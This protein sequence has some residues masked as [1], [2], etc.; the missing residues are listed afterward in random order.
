M[1]I[2][3]LTTAA[4]RAFHKA[5]FELKKHSPEILVVAGVVGTVASAVMA[6]KATTKVNFVL[7][8]TKSKIDI[9]HDG[10]E[11]GEVKGLLENGE[12]GMVPYS[13]EDSQKDLTIV[14]AQTGLKL[15][16]LYAPAVLLGAASITSILVGHRILHKRNLAL[17]AAYTAVDTGFKQYRG[18]VVERLGEKMDK[19]LLYNIKAKEIEETVV[20]EDGT[21]TTVK[22]TVEV[23]DPVGAMSPYTVCF[24]ETCTGWVRDAERN[25]FFLLRQQQHANELLQSRGHL[26]LNEVLDMVGAQRTE[27][28]QIVGWVYKDDNKTGDNYIDFGIFNIHSEA[29]R[30]FV[31]GLEKSIWLTFNVDGPI[32]KCFNK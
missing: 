1:K 25:K 16:K 6:C 26:F 5:G 29:S 23:A 13:A 24:D 28:G 10:A 3:E 21:E 7:E 12:V 9:I 31:N 22:K 15:V 2:N 17:A 27:A 32:I 8:E 30:N 14:Y 20:N 19:E 11:K 4:T 18:R